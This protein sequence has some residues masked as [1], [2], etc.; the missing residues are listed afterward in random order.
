MPI[1]G[2]AVEGMGA[3]RA[4]RSLRRQ[5]QRRVAIADM[6]AQRRVAAG[7]A[8]GFEEERQAQLA[9]SRA[10]AVAAASGRAV[11]KS[12]EDIIADIG[13]EGIYRK[14]LQVYEA[15]EDARM[16]RAAGRADASALNDQARALRFGAKANFGASLFSMGA[17]PMLSKYGGG[18]P[19]SGSGTDT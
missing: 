18:G 1:F 8:A 4:S 15:E 3:T 7:Q 6:N 14:A 13:A 19:G 5:G 10:L 17:S 12:A 9:A 2:S 16:I 11:N